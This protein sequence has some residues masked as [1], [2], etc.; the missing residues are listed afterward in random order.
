VCDTG[1]P[2][3][4]HTLTTAEYRSTSSRFDAR[5]SDTDGVDLVVR[6][7]HVAPIAPPTIMMS[8]DSSTEI[9]CQFLDAGRMDV[10]WC[11]TLLPS[12]R[13]A[14]NTCPAGQSWLQARPIK[15]RM[16]CFHSIPDGTSM[17][18]LCIP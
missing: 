10:N 14:L 5:L 4:S 3:W 2:S 17:C 13:S 9:A 12:H 7:I 18:R 6:I 11:A 15:S 1:R 16:V 8:T